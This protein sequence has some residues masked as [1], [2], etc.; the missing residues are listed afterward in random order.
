MNRLAVVVLSVI[1]A[2]GFVVNE[3]RSGL[4]D[5]G[6]I[7]SPSGPNPSVSGRNWLLWATSSRTR[8]FITENRKVWKLSGRGGWDSDLY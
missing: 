2:V 5:L 7:D 6:E 8:G 1:I 4:G 3:Y